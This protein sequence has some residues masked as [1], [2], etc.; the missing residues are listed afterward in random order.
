MPIA[1]LLLTLLTSW[2]GKGCSTTKADKLNHCQQLSSKL[3]IGLHHC[4]VTSNDS[5][6]KKLEIL[7]LCILLN[8]LLN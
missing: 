2:H 3:L 5:E 6:E 8:W 7:Q 4:V 1:K